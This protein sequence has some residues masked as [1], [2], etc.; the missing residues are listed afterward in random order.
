V[1]WAGIA[2]ALIIAPDPVRF[3]RFVHMTITFVGILALDRFIGF[4]QRGVNP[5]A[6]ENYLAMGRAAGLATMMA[7]V[8]LSISRTWPARITLAIALALYSLVMWIGG[9]RGP[10]LAALAG[11]LVMSLGSVRL[12]S[13]VLRLPFAKAFI[14]LGLV[15]AIVAIWV[16]PE[17]RLLRRFDVLISQESGGRSAGQRMFYYAQ[18][19]NVAAEAPIVGQGLGGWPIA[20]GYTDA[21][22]YP[23][24]IFL[25]SLTEGGVVGLL[26]LC[27]LL[28]VGLT[29]LLSANVFDDPP[30]LIVFL[31][32]VNTFMN[33]QFSGDLS[34]NRSLFAT[35][36]FMAIASK[37]WSWHAVRSK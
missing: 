14:A 29:R 13:G 18:S 26:L 24:N 27:T 12:G 9:G 17:S 19:L 16:G 4:L 22:R 36:G 8:L 33:S 35:I 32:F 15:S 6:I 31:C 1:L 3:R 11:L 2:P 21:R 34:D 23:H 28:G 37:P 20:M 10:L 30:R 7:L 5:F 25:E